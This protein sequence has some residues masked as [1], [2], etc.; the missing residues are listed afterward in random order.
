MDAY[1]ERYESYND[2]SFWAKLG[3]MVQKA[4]REI[5]ERALVLYYCLKDS[6]TPTWARGVIIG[7]LGYFVLPVDAIPDV[8]PFTGFADDFGILVSALVSVARH[9][10][11]EHRE[12]ARQNL[13]RWFGSQSPAERS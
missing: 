12:L 7:A 1:P 8:V 2:E 11:D 3:R 6:D 5:V 9:V 10:K 13:S 4:G